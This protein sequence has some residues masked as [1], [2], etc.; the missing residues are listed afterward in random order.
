[1]SIKFSVLM[2][3]YEKERPEY[4]ARCLDSLL[5]QTCL[6]SEV[7]LVEDG[8]VGSALKDVI[9]QYREGLNIVS[10]LLDKNIGLAA[11]L[12]YGLA[13]CQYDL[14]ARM[15]TDDIARRDRFKIQI[16]VM[17]GRPEIGVCGGRIMSFG[18]GA[19]SP[20]IQKFLP[21]ENSEIFK[22]AKTRNP[23]N[24]PTVFFRKK[25]VEQFGGYPIVRNSQD[26]ALWALMLK[27]GVQFCNLDDVL[28]EM[29]MNVAIIERRGFRYFCGEFEVLKFQ[30]EIGFLNFI[31]FLRNSVFRFVLRSIP[32]PVKRLIY[33]RFK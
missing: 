20:V 8:V 24:H 33:R 9:E 28:V 6:A 14:V 29:R 1:M 4:L 7:V 5:G 12:N 21:I 11:A 18:N 19:S 15:D 27:N 2:S 16:G 32:S 26:Y 13:H 23:I 25:L 31:E 17:L 30:K 10:V 3:V 22:V